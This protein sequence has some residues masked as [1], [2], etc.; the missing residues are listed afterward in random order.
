MFKNKNISM[1]YLSKRIASLFQIHIILGIFLGTVTDVNAQSKPNILWVTIEDTSPQFIGCY[2]NDV[3]KT[4]NIDRLAANGI[5]FTNAFSTNS[6]CSPSRTT[7]ITGVRTYETG[8]GHHRSKYRIPE[9]MKGFPHFMKQAGYYTSNNSKTDYNVAGAPA[10]TKNAWNESSEQ[11]GWWNR[12]PGQPFFAVFNFNDSHQSRTMTFPYATY[13]QEVLDKLPAGSKIPDDAFP[14]PPIYHD[15]PEMRKQMARVYNAIQYTDYKIG[16][17]LQRLEKDGLTDSTII[18]FYS[19]HGEGIPRGKTNGIDLGY[20]VPMVIWFPEMYRHL[21]PWG[22][23]GV[24]HEL[25]D[26][27]DMAP[28]MIAL[29]GGKVPNYMKGRIFLGENR[30]EAPSFIGLSSDRSDNGIDMIRSI[31]DGRF[32]YSRNY[33]PF[34]P[35]ARYINYMEIA[36]M[37]QLM[38]QDLASG[39]LNE[40]QRKL[41]D[42]REPEFLFDLKNDP[43]ELNNLSSN[44]EYKEILNV[45]RRR[46]DTLVLQS[47]DVMFL[48]E[49]E[50]AAISD[51]KQTPYEF[52]MNEQEYPI[53]KIYEVASLSGKRGK[54][55]AQQQ[56]SYLKNSN[57]IIRYWAI[58]GLRSQ[59]DA[60]LRSYQ[61]NILQAMDDSYPPVKVTAAAIV[62][63]LFNDSKAE[64]VLKT[65]IAGSNEHIALMTINYMLYFNNKQPFKD[66]VT[67][68][69]NAKETS[70]NVSWAAKDYIR[71]MKNN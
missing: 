26:F 35:E 19:D 52:R 34:M 18:F 50:L 7:L 28:T 36:E 3:A 42:P 62:F 47:R 54:D 55:I 59:P 69:A 37:K 60:I 53:S 38:R 1:H 12:K 44:P 30:K 49:Y 66:A 4:P 67:A 41:F 15:S 14:M 20:R 63:D 71:S 5:R 6:V 64:N 8:T 10:F 24:V 57:P 39:K 21:S 68:L 43:W 32:M 33:M 56:I 70:S 17:V 46:L 31:T 13:V 40:H 22:K 29:A 58:L 16:E 48:P 9:F 27:E 45:M 23:T 2:G 25:I 61:K 51:R 11:A 65:A